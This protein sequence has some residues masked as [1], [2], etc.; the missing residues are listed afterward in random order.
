MRSPRCLV[1]VVA[2]C[3]AYFTVLPTVNASYRPVDCTYAGSAPPEADLDLYYSFFPGVEDTKGRSVR[4]AIEFDAMALFV[5]T[6]YGGADV[7]EFL[8]TAR[9]IGN[10]IA[11]SNVSVPEVVA[12]WEAMWSEL[13]YQVLNDSV[14]MAASG[15]DW[16]AVAA[17]AR[18]ATYLQ[19][20]ERFS[21]HL[22]PEPLRVF[23]LSMSLFT[24]AVS[25]RYGV[26]GVRC[27]SVSIPYTGVLTLPQVFPRVSPCT[28]HDFVGIT[29]SYTRLRG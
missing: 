1:L 6:R 2:T 22:A 27:E 13:G 12:T 26:G 17:K 29:M 28:A 19:L 8:V 23:N 7:A 10:A 18:A 14:A 20:S 5:A 15:D 25:S 4:A 21:D 9:R 11:S 24:D 3:V 16:G